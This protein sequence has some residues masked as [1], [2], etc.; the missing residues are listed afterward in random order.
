MLWLLCTIAHRFEGS[1]HH[2]NG[3]SVQKSLNQSLPL[4]VILYVCALQ[5][6]HGEQFV[7]ETDTEV[8]PKLLKYVYDSMEEKLPFPKVGQLDIEQS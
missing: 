1:T 3:C 5:I 6:S 2:A 7:S 4:P 8:I